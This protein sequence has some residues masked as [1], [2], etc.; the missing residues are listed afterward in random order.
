MIN[1]IK[2]LKKE[3]TIGLIVLIL[4]IIFMGGLLIYSNLQT[5]QN[6]S[7][8]EDGRIFDEKTCSMLKSYGDGIIIH[9]LG[10]PHC[11]IVI[12]IL[13]EIE[14]EKNLTF[15][16]YDL[17]IESD[18]KIVLEDMNLIPLGVPI[19]IYDCKVYVGQK[20]KE[21]YMEIIKWVYSR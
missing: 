9:Q 5:K 7:L 3:T 18:R 6:Q 11:T 17:A 1:K 16:Y 10:C 19:F 4:I 14:S 8:L 21:E 20:T 12:P 15:S 2:N 13:R